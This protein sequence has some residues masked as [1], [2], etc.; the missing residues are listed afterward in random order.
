MRDPGNEVA[1]NQGPD[2]RGSSVFR[3]SVF[4]R[5]PKDTWALGTRLTRAILVSRTHDPSGLRLGSRALAWPDFLSMRSVFVSY[6]Q[7]ITFARFD[8]IRGLPVSGLPVLNEARSLPQARRILG[9]GDENV[10]RVCMQ[11]CM[12]HKATWSSGHV[13]FCFNRKLQHFLKFP[14][15]WQ[16]RKFLFHFTQFRK[17]SN[18]CWMTSAPAY[19]YC[20]DLK[21][22]INGFT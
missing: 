18:C 10:T 2:N 21:D 3:S 19:D 5:W 11:S 16:R 20:Q 22:Y 17:F 8:G 12:Q 6:S 4:W 1:D 13:V 9:S 7:P 15:T 14:K